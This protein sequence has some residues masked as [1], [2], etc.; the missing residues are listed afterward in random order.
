MKSIFIAITNLGFG[1]QFGALVVFSADL[2]GILSPLSMFS[3]I[4]SSFLQETIPFYIEIPNIYLGLV[5]EFGP[6]RIMDLAIVCP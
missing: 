2:F 3:I 6:Q 1:R 4:Q 5:F